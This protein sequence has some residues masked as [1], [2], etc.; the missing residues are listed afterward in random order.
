MR[1]LRVLLVSLITFGL[2]C[3]ATAAT[4]SI[5]GAHSGNYVL[6]SMSVDS[7]GNIILSVSPGS[8]IPPTP[9]ALSLAL[10]TTMLAA[11][12]VGQPYNQSVTMT[13]AGGTSP[14]AYACNGSGTATGL[15]V[16]P[17]PTNAAVCT[18][19]ATNPTAGAFTV[20]FTVTDSATPQ[21]S[22]SQ[23]LSFN[24]NATAP[25]PR[26]GV[27]LTAKNTWTPQTIGPGDVNSYYFVIDQNATTV[28]VGISSG[29]W[30]TDQDIMLSKVAQPT[31]D[32]YR[33]IIVPQLSVSPYPLNRIVSNPP[34]YKIAPDNNESILL[35]INASAGD[36]F[37]LS[38]FN[39]S[40]TTG[41]F[42]ILWNSY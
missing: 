36:V 15:I 3:A 29:D 13:A 42:S 5:Q 30:S 33:R 11:G 2:V 8:T 24:I 38:V 39:P 4:V 1:G 9:G 37:Y 41:K 23:S 32:D 19:T 16:T 40:S 20:A 25:P 7:A 18:I 35:K 12:T 27:Q 14:Y 22:A 17:S 34:W 10:S 31:W 26:V 21:A 6:S 28:T